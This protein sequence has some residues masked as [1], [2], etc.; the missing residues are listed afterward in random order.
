MNDERDDPWKDWQ[1]EGHPVGVNRIRDI[2]VLALIKNR[3]TADEERYV[4]MFRLEDDESRSLALRTLSRFASSQELSFSWYD[5][6]VL[7][8]RIRDEH[9]ANKEES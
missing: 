4:F 2:T 5:A 3:G 6:A 8:K 9:L 7:S 1:D